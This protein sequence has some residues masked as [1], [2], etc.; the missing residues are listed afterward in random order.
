MKYRNV[1]FVGVGGAGMAPLAE[2]TLRGG[3]R[4][5]GSD[6][7]ENSHTRKLRELGVAMTLGHAAENLPP[8]TDAVVF[9]S[10]AAADNPELGEA[11]K[12]GLP[13]FRR[14]EYLGIWSAQY[15]TVVAVSGSHGK[16]S[17]TAMLG[18]A[19]R[20]RRCRRG[21]RALLGR[22]KCRFGRQPA[23]ATG[24]FRDRSRPKATAHTSFSTANSGLCPTLMRPRLERPRAKLRRI[25]QRSAH[26][27]AACLFGSP[28]CDALF[29]L[30]R[31]G[32]D[33]AGGLTQRGGKCPQPA[34]I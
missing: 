27:P 8:E 2:L 9:T 31:R 16:T 1:H 15:R 22:A 25:F 4:V 19:S 20:W 11:R 6:L 13:L 26:F 10:A 33:C 14:G 30:H 34:G 32:A 18:T 21:F 28:E 5:S 23:M 12:R 24:I 7:I 29:A 17:I 3:A